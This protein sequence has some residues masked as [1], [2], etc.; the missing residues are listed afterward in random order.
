MKLKEFLLE[1]KKNELENIE[2]LELGD[3]EKKYINLLNEFF[4][5]EVEDRD[6]VLEDLDKDN[7]F[8]YKLMCEW[9]ENEFIVE[10]DLGLVWYEYSLEDLFRDCFGIGG[11]CGNDLFEIDDIDEKLYGVGEVGTTFK[12]FG[13]IKNINFDDELFLKVIDPPLNLQIRNIDFKNN[14]VILGK[15]E[16]FEREGRS[17]GDW[18]EKIYD[19][20]MLAKEGYLEKI[21]D[22]LNEVL[23][24]K[25]NRRSNR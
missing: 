14:T 25:R 17:D 12:Q 19:L 21:I 3:F 6:I 5:R 10:N 8:L 2:D 15:W 18:N 16:N 22:M 13:K 4:D 20:D 9:F 23:D 24:K 1:F 7:G 11:E